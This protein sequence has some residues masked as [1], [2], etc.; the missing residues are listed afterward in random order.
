MHYCYQHYWLHVILLCCYT[1]ADDKP[2]LADLQYM[3]YTG[4]D[5]R[6][7]P[8]RLMDKLKPHWRALAIALKFPVHE[9]TALESKDDRV[10]RVFSEW[11]QGANQDN[12]P[13]PVTWETLIKALRH[14]NIQDEATV[15]ETHLVDT[16]ESVPQPGKLKVCLAWF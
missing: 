10:Y 15:L 9:I 4:E 12:D 16:S 14:A 3:S 13:R 7:V 1:S 11:L 8:F 6:D 2:A 5:G